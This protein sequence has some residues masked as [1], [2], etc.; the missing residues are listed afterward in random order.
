MEIPWRVKGYVL[1]LY[2][3]GKDLEVRTAD[4]YSAQ[5]KKSDTLRIGVALRKKVK[6]IRRYRNFV[7]MLQAERSERIVPGADA[8]T[9]LGLL[10]TLYSP[11]EERRGI[12]VF[13]LEEC[14]TAE[15]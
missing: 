1:P 10:R 13:E 3:K 15:P 5:V 12:I 9:V 14:S 6:N 2:D 11:A 8:E 7:V 4:G